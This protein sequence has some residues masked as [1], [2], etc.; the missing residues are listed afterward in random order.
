MGS[1]RTS[2]IRKSQAESASFYLA[3][4]SCMGTTLMM[5]IRRKQFWKNYYA[6]TF[7]MT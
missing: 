6:T 1:G 7:R 3:I 2:F 4:R 5:T